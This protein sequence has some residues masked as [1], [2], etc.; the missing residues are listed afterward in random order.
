MRVY[1]YTARSAVRIVCN[2]VFYLI[3]NIVRISIRAILI[4]LPNC[5]EYRIVMDSE[6]A[7]GIRAGTRIVGLGVPVIKHVVRTRKAV[8][9]HR[10]HIVVRIEV[11]VCHRTRRIGAVLIINH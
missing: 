10:H 2:A 7:G 4:K 6:C 11:A 8:R 3:R 1:R 9:K 5:V